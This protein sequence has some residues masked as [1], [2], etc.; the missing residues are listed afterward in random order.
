MVDGAV[1]GRPSA[2][3][4]GAGARASDLAAALSVLDLDDCE[5]EVLVRATVNGST[6]TVPSQAAEWQSQE[7]R[8]A[9]DALANDGLV[10]TGADDT[11]VHVAEDLLSATTDRARREGAR[12]AEAL[13]ARAVAL[14]SAI[15]SRCSGTPR[16]LRQ[17]DDQEA[18][19]RDV[20]L[21]HR[22]VINVYPSYLPQNPDLETLNVASLAA[23]R[24]AAGSRVEFD[25]VSSR[26]LRMPMERDY[27]TEQ[28]SV[29]GSTVVMADEV[30][31]R[32]TLL[33]RRLVVVP[34]DPLD[35]EAGAWV[36]DEPDVVAQVG[37]HM[38]QHQAEA[39]PWAP[40][41]SPELSDREKHVIRLL[42]RGLTD[43]SIARRLLVTD[44]TVRRTVSDLMT[45]LGA[46]SRF[47]LAIECAKQALI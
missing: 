47:A 34:M 13:R 42:A 43:D 11:V 18:D 16:P 20:I 8:D 35:H 45:K 46:D 14:H 22:I 19:F 40:C 24:D 41:T 39:K 21:G 28:A 17:S 7:L 25:I 31:I 2:A 6:A 9:A 30:P 44:R 38:S 26:R 29:P 4:A 3:A 10:R 15:M 36:I 5:R 23:T 12:V 37:L 33:D 32:M 1:G 27:F